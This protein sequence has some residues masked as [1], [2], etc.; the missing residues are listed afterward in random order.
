MH[1]FACIDDDLVA[2]RQFDA[3]PT[4]TIIK[5]NCVPLTDEL[6]APAIKLKQIV[7]VDRDDGGQLDA[8]DPKRLIDEDL[9]ADVAF[10]GVLFD[11]DRQ[12]L[13]LVDH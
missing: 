10:E 3:G 6:L 5:L 12:R 2:Q 7:G 9:L 1:E 13:H 8:R 11:S 4:L